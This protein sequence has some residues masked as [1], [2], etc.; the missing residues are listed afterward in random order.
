M[1]NV[2]NIIEYRKGKAVTLRLVAQENIRASAS[3]LPIL[4][5]LARKLNELADKMRTR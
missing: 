5:P 1:S 2:V 3:D 4:S